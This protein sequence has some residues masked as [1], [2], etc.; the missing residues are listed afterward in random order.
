MVRGEGVVLLLL[1]AVTSSEILKAKQ[2]LGVTFDSDKLGDTYFTQFSKLT[3][4]SRVANV[5]ADHNELLT[6]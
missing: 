4:C 3:M 5:V 6:Q 2:K 1:D